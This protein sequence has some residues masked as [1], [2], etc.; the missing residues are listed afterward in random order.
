MVNRMQTRETT[1]AD[2]LTG[3]FSDP[4]FQ[5][6]S[7]FR[8]LM[9]GMA[10]P[11]SLRTVEAPVVPP[12]PFGIAA[13]AIAL[14]LCDHDTPVWL[15]PALAKSTAAQWLGFHCGAPL[16]GDKAQSRFAFLDASA[17]LPPFCMFATGSQEY[18]D[19]STTLVIEVGALTGG[20]AL[21]LTGPGIKDT[22][23]ISPKGL[24]DTFLRNWDEN[25]GVF[26]R[27]IDVVLTCGRQFLCLPRTTKITTGEN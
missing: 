1:G 19:R 2:A 17:P 23:T 27:G 9:D 7:V 24:Q 20:A 25:R 14:A 15:S 3:G 16:T 21:I 22:A 4:V 5:S 11:G 6:Q 12:T 18:P 13:G 26:P 8:A 10:Q